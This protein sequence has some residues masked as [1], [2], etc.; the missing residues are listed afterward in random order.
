MS[1]V[2]EAAEGPPRPST[3]WEV[4]LHSPS[5]A[6]AAPV[7]K[8]PACQ[9][10][11]CERLGFDPWVRRSLAGENSILLQYSCLENLMDRGAWWVTV[12][13]VTELDTAERLSHST[14]E[15]WEDKFRR[16]ACFKPWENETF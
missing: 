4:T 2:R 5:S 7:V 13:G 10:R 12:H 1:T 3:G 16:R 14:S 15:Y 11:R 8:E 6:Q 9:R